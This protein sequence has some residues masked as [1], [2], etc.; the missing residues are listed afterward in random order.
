MGEMSSKEEVGAA[1][2]GMMLVGPDDVHVE[3]RKCLEERAVEFLTKL[4]DHVEQ[5]E[6]VRDVCATST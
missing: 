3:V 6:E 5:F 2:K 4:T 1:M